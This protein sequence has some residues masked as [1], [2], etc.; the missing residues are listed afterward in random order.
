MEVILFKLKEVLQAVLPIVA[1]VFILHFTIVPLESYLL[2]R[3]VIGSILIIAGL[4]IFLLGIELGVSPIGHAMGKMIARSNQIL[5]VVIAGLA[6]GFIISIAEPDLHILAG[7]VDSITAG[8][9]SKTT[10]LVVVS[11]GVAA[12]LTL[13][14]VRVVSQFPLHK[15]FTI[16]YVFILIL[17]FFSSSE[18]LAIAFDS[19]GATTGALSTPF[20]LALGV[21]VSGMKKDSK[22]AEEDSF[23]LVGFASAGAIIAVLLMGLLFPVQEMKSAQINQPQASCSIWK[24]FFQQ[25]PLV[26]AEVIA[27]LAPLLCLLLL[28]HKRSFKM[29]RHAMRH[30][31]FGLL[32]TFFGLVLFMIGVNAGFMDIGSEV[33][34]QVASLSNRAILILIGFVMGLVTVIAEPA[35]Y[36]L[37][38]Q[39][40]E[41]TSGYVKRSIVL[42][43]LSIGVGASIALSMIRILV[44]GIKLWHYLFPAYVVSMI[45][46]WIVPELFVG[47]AYDAGGVAS[48]PMTASFILAFSNGA[49]EA[50][51]GASVL[52]DG[53]GLIAMVAMAPVL[54]LQILGFI[55]KLKSKKGWD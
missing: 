7:Q 20:I 26:A 36:V 27:A 49:A 52:V 25:V 43:T 55:F 32:F 53:F 37:T 42:L 2:I 18:F 19:S 31:L 10:L 12:V 8:V 22:A 14:L 29:T 41:V 23:G 54:F 45:L 6:L 39:I 50:V 48:G 44:P 24:P 38:H 30:V 17:G 4:T 5:V 35:V 3:F 15:L 51:E 1:L 40:E 16:V 33:G 11:I 34:Y 21:G 9:I 13:G 28:F 47:I 46:S